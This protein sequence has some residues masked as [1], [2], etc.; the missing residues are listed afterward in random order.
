[1]RGRSRHIGPAT[2]LVEAQ[3]LELAARRAIIH[4]SASFDR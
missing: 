3:K 4:Q 2:R 1:M